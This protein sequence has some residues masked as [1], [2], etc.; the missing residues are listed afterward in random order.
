MKYYFCKQEE[1]NYCVPACLQSI[2][3]RRTGEILEQKE[4]FDKL[5]PAERGVFLNEDNLNKCLGEFGLQSKY[6]H[7]KRSMYDVDEVIGYHFKV[8]TDI[9]FAFYSDILFGK[10]KKLNH[11][12]LVA[13]FNHTSLCIL[14]PE[15]NNLTGIKYGDINDI[16]HNNGQSGFYLINT[17][18]NFKNIDHLF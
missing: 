10:E 13:K 8:N 9:I 17:P 16:T 14:D 7:P 3:H 4:I 1:K 5:E 11:A 12:A 2:I 6:Y 18:S 15:F